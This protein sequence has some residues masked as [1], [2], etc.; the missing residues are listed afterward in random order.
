M[1]LTA[2]LSDSRYEYATRAAQRFWQ[3]G[4]LVL[5]IGAGDGRMKPLL[6]SAGYNWMGFDLRPS[7]EIAA[8]DLNFPCPQNL[9]ANLVILLDVIEHLLNPG[10]A[11]SHISKVMAPNGRLIITTPNPRWSRSRFYALS[12]GFLACFTQSDLDLNGHVFPVWPHILCKILRDSGLEVI[13]YSTLDGRTTWP[14]GLSLRYPVRC[15]VAAANKAVER[16]DPT[17]CGMSFAVIAG[18]SLKRSDDEAQR[19]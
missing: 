14:R 18:R 19:L 9:S 16:I 2:T 4:A 5:D 13:E 11:L 3:P 1:I 12:T 8:W 7:G 15:L 10:I 17:A 6:E